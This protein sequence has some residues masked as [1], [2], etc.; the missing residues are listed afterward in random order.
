[1]VTL[2]ETTVFVIDPSVL[3]IYLATAPPICLDI[4]LPLNYPLGYNYSQKP[5]FPVPPFVLYILDTVL[6]IS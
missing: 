1:M 6:P 5:M 3:T 2:F 4:V